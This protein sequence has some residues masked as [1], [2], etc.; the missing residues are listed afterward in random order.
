ML[1][2]ALHVKR[3]LCYALM[4]SVEAVR[5]NALIAKPI[6]L[7]LVHLVLRD[8]TS[9]VVHVSSALKNALNAQALGALLVLMAIMQIAM[10]FVYQNV[11]F[12][13]LPAQIINQQPASH[14]KAVLHWLVL[15]VSLSK[16]VVQILHV[17]TA[18]RDLT[19]S[20]FLALASA[21]QTFQTVSSVPKPILICVLS[22][23]MDSS[24]QVER[25]LH[26]KVLALLVRA[27]R[28]VLDA[29]P[30]ILL[31]KTQ[32]KESAL[33]VSPHA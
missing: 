31:P 27:V 28:F 1:I 11:L 3:A 22:A 29:T 9:P 17:P 16:A 24:C 10:E 12:L 26:V 15:H 25:V 33:L 14:V 2:P 13:A 19:M 21:A 18:D 32:L 7:L 20:L 8:S 6:T 5:S 4:E 23:K 30:A